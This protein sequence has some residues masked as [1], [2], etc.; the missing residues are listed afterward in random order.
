MES[1]NNDWNFI[2]ISARAQVKIYN[3][4]ESSFHIT[5]FTSSGLFNIESD[6]DKSYLLEI[7]NEQLK[8]LHDLLLSYDIE[9]SNWNECLTN[10]NNPL[11]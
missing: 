9:L 1:F 3:K 7:S 10:M 11:V 2:S 4:D 6:S 5:T 8:E